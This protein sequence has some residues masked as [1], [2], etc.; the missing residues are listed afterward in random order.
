VP[1]VLIGILTVGAGLGAGLGLSEGTV[2]ANTPAHA[3]TICQL[4]LPQKE[5]SIILHTGEVRL[6]G[7]G[8]N[9]AYVGAGELAVVLSVTPSPPS[10]GVPYLNQPDAQ[11]VSV[12]GV[13]ASW[14]FASVST[15]TSIL[16]FRSEDAI[17]QIGLSPTFTNAKAKAEEAMVDVL[18]HGGRNVRVAT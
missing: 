11:L 13:R 16:A 5:A 7:E 18:R 9:C 14:R 2:A 8:A 12:D 15:Q 1:F 4:L 10:R 3:S 6:E 17:V